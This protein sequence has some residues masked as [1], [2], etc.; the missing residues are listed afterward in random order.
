[1]IFSD[2]IIC[3]KFDFS[4]ENNMLLDFSGKK[5]FNIK[6]KIKFHSIIIWLWTN[7]EQP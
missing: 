2:I 6:Y 5:N 3:I 7:H 4:Q 1:M